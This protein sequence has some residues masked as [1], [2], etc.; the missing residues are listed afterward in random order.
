MKA[1]KAR[2]GHGSHYKA[3]HSVT[4]TT[5]LSA[6]SELSEIIIRKSDTISVPVSSFVCPYN[7]LRHKARFI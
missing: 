4:H 3:A 6:S 7:P 2:R 5:A 1:E